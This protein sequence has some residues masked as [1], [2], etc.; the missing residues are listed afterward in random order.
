MSRYDLGRD[1]LAAVLS[2]QPAYRVN[3]VF[4]GLFRRLAEPGE[5]T[6]LPRALRDRLSRAPEFASAFCFVAESVADRGSTVK[7]LL[8]TSDAK[9]IETVLMRYR[10]R[11]TV[12]VSSQAGCAMGC[13]FCATG[14]G[15]FGRHLRAGEIVEQ[16]VIAARRCRAEGW[17]E[18]AN[19]VL[20]GMGEPL[21]NF[22]SVWAAVEVMNRDLCLAARHLTISTVGVVPGILQLAKKPLQVNLAVSL[23]AA[24]D[25]L[26]DEL[27]PLNRKYPLGAVIGACAEYRA[28]TG[29]RISF[30]WAC[31]AG[32][33]DRRSDAIELAALARPLGAHVNLIPLN[34]T[35]GGLSRGL[36]GSGRESVVSLRSWLQQAGVNVTVR[37]NR[38]RSIAAACGQ[39]AATRS[40]TD[41]EPTAVSLTRT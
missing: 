33:N 28:A 3:Q 31:I 35:P 37:H 27:V 13:T 29:R 1:E 5:L 22:K 2:D 8:E 30:E 24:N 25:S 9:D 38:G 26:R 6:D 16:V 20:M 12:C 41:P 7:W 17:G 32:V 34:P 11:A 19:V 18:L 15:G 36:R 4:D 10:D 14:D 21:A 39:L 23:H 40:R